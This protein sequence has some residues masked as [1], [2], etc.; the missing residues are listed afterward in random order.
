MTAARQ[1][2]IQGYTAACALGER[3]DVIAR[4]LF[5]P[6][7]TPVSGRAAL[8]DGREVPVGQLPFDIGPHRPNDVTG[9][10]RTNRV[11]T[12]AYAD[13]ADAAEAAI[14]RYGPARVG[15][16]I[17]T[18]TSGVGEGG[19]AVAARLKDQPWPVGFA[20]DVQELYDPARAMA[21]LSGA[22]G[23]GLCGF[24]G[25]HLGRQGHRRRRADDRC[26]PVRRR[27]LRRG[28]FAVRPDP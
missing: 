28:G 14:E 15:V 24:H 25:L 16:V 1:A 17:G 23:T 27:D 13:I 11:L 20:F 8:L 10:S 5:S 7:P 18:S 19:E 3:P 21:E 9:R 4:A 2:W 6:T 22:R 26:G 12:H